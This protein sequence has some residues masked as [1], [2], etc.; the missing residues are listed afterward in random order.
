MGA[1]NTQKLNM[2][3]KNKE[4]MITDLEA[5]TKTNA[6]IIEITEITE[7]IEII[8]TIEIIG[9]ETEEVTVTIVTIGMLEEV[10]I[11]RKKLKFK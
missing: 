3:K 4:E 2:R 10:I 7:I 9:E 6:E 1:R 8:E 5:K 11:D